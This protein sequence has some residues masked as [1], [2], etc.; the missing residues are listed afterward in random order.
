MER[1]Y[2]QLIFRASLPVYLCFRIRIDVFNANPFRRAQKESKLLSFNTNSLARLG[3]TLILAYLLYV[4]Y[5]NVPCFNIRH[6]DRFLISGA[7]PNQIPKIA[8]NFLYK[9]LGVRDVVYEYI[10]VW[11]SRRCF[12]KLF[13]RNNYRKMKMKKIFKEPENRSTYSHSYII[14]LTNIVALSSYLHL[15]IIF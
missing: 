15:L 10:C 4:Q 11:K 12:L 9:Y 8:S 6:T 1:N 13:A 14:S 7:K 5:V 2:S 3:K